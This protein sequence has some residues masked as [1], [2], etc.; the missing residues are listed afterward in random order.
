MTTT[1]LIPDLWQ[2]YHQRLTHYVLKRINNK[3]DAQ[4]IVQT[5]FL[6]IQQHPPQLKTM[7]QLE[8][9]LLQVTKNTLVDYWR[10]L[11]PSTSL[12]EEHDY[13]LEEDPE[14]NEN[15][16]LNLSCCLLAMMKDLPDKYRQAV[17]LADLKEVKHKDIAQMMGISESG[18]KSRV[19]RG[20]EKLRDLLVSC[21]GSDCS[22]H[23]QS[24]E[25]GCCHQSN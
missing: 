9:W 8:A 2:D 18:V 11:K 22:C 24:H 20:R 5:V 12:L 13:A 7:P 16:W 1:T 15:P 4:D 25:Q 23:E 17:E 21:C 19:K 3:N 6:K 10:K 14:P